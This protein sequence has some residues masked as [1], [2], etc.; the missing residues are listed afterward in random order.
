MNKT[1]VQTISPVLEKKIKTI[2]RLSD[3]KLLE[4]R[5]ELKAIEK[6]TQELIASVN[7]E[8]MA[9]IE[10]RGEEKMRIHV[11]EKTVHKS[12][13]PVFREVSLVEGAKYD[14][15]KTVLDT[16]KLTE[17]W[18]KGKKI[19][20]LLTTEYVKVTKKKA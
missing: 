19:K 15:L 16:T 10:D 4:K 13:M 11:G 1:Q 17:L 7:A 2:Q 8:F 12:T 9:R 18:H 20:G 6:E 5:D 3:A 14:A